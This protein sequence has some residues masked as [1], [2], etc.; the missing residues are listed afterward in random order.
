MPR[1]VDEDAVQSP[2][3]E[4]TR[5]RTLSLTWALVAAFVVGAPAAYLLGTELGVVRYTA[6]GRLWVGDTTTPGEA[7]AWLSDCS[8]A[9]CAPEVLTPVALDQRLYLRAPD[10]YAYAFASFS[11][12]DHYVPGV[13][14]L[15]VDESGDQFALFDGTSSL[16]Q[17]GT[18]ESPI[19]ES[20]GFRWALSPGTLPAGVVIEF[21]LL[22]PKEATRE[23]SARLATDRDPRENF[24]D[25][26]LTG[27]DPQQAADVL[28]ALMNRYVEVAV[29]SG[30]LISLEIDELPEFMEAAPVPLG[31]VAC[32]FGTRAL[33]GDPSTPRFEDF[34]PE[35]V[36]LDRALVPVRPSGDSRFPIAAVTFLGCFCLAFGGFLRLSRTALMDKGDL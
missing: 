33:A 5:R 19:G 11:V 7:P 9:L 8:G 13:F 36:I 14:Q 24:E 12:A 22:S 10:P 4:K 32:A 1:F 17:T 26:S 30:P 31:V 3:S 25:I 21:S 15:T 35:A 6:E 27:P 23:L 2:A 16:V 20:V 18:F 34:G 29:R 28:N